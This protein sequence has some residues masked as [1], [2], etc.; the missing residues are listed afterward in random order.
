M[1][2]IGFCGMSHLGLCYSTAAAEKGFQI[3]CFDF[4]EKKI[5]HLKKSNLEVEEPE[6]KELINKNKKKYYIRRIF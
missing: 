6:L 1:Y 2:K 5:N 3:T 4:D